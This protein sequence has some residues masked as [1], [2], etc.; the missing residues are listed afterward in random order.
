[1]LL[2]DA[3]DGPLVHLAEQARLRLERSRHVMN[4]GGGSHFVNHIYKRHFKRGAVPLAGVL[5]GMA[6]GIAEQCCDIFLA[7]ESDYQT[8]AQCVFRE[9]L[10]VRY[11]AASHG[12]MQSPG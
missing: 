7:K 1:M 6:T 10:I 11:S 9:A 4:L 8:A 3:H 5:I 12:R 2:Q